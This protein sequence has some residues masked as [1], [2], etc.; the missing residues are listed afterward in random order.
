MIN[1]TRC[2]RLAAINGVGPEVI[3]NDY[4]VEMILDAIARNDRL[5]SWLVF[6]GGTC[7]HK[8]YFDNYRFSEDMDFIFGKQPGPDAVNAE[9]IKML[10]ILKKANPQITG[11]TVQSKP[12]RLQIYVQYDIVPEIAKQDKTLKLDL[13]GAEE[14]PAYSAEPL[15][16][17]HDEFRGQNLSMNSYALEAVIADKI[18]RIISLEK[19]A[20]DIYDLKQLFDRD[21]KTDIIN[22]EFRKGHSHDIDPVDLLRRINDNYFRKMWEI[23]LK[24]QIKDLPDYNAHIVELSAMIRKKYRSYFER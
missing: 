4:L 23:R 8:V 24:H 13:C 3:E 20:R 21:V 11:W 7:L 12:G 14:M 18:S 1:Y 17:V 16:L 6:R 10:E 22:A 2:V 15:R 19:E 9:I 5:D